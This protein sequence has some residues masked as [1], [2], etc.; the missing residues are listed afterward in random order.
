MQIGNGNRMQIFLASPCITGINLVWGDGSG[1]IFRENLNWLFEGLNPEQGMIR[2]PSSHE[3][4]FA[5]ALNAITFHT[6][7]A[8][9]DL[10]DRDDVRFLAINDNFA[11]ASVSERMQSHIMRHYVLRR[12]GDFFEVIMTEFENIWHYIIEINNILPDFDFALLPDF[13]ISRNTLMEGEVFDAIIQDIRSDEMIHEDEAV[14]FVSGNHEFVY[15]V[16]TDGQRFL[17]H[18]RH[19]FGWSHERIASHTD[20]RAAMTRLNPNPPLYILRQE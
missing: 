9:D 13:D 19:E 3:Q 7:G 12:H 2:R 15:L 11:F 6:R 17:A 4:I 10:V 8:F 5:N 14:E 16:F 1:V 20:A 18:F